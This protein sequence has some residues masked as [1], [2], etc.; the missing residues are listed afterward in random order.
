MIYNLLSFSLK[1]NT[2]SNE[3]DWTE[4]IDDDLE[5]Q[6]EIVKENL[7][8][9]FIK[10]SVSLEMKEIKIEK[11]I[12]IE[13]VIEIEKEVNI[14]KAIEIEKEV[15]DKNSFNGFLE[16]IFSKDENNKNDNMIFNFLDLF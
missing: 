3:N 1:K 7:F 8:E 11:S 10:K 16:K 9:N 12:E 2:K 5:E 6:P 15:E 14:E 13:K 4:I